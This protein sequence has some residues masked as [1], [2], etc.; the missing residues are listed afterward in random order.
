MSLNVYRSLNPPEIDKWEVDYF[1]EDCEG[2]KLAA[3]ILGVR[4]N[5][6]VWVPVATLLEYIEGR[7]EDLDG[8]D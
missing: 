4:V 5:E 1:D 7:K 6:G 8:T 3:P 2:K